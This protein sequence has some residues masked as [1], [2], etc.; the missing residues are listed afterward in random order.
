MA[1]MVWLGCTDGEIRGETR[2][3]FGE[4][5]SGLAQ[6]PVCVHGRHAE[7]LEAEAAAMEVERRRRIEGGF[8]RFALRMQ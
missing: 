4:E 8:R 2:S 7:C 1:G 6:R 5:G 3:V